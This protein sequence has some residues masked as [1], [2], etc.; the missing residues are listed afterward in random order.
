MTTTLTDWEK[1]MPANPPSPTGTA[2][3][4]AAPDSKIGG[5]IQGLLAHKSWVDTVVDLID[6]LHAWSWC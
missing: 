2:R 6:L 3:S 1:A 4:D 5:R